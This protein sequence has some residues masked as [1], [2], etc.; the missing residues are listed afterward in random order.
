MGTLGAGPSRSKTPILA[1]HHQVVLEVFFVHSGMLVQVME[2][3]S[4]V[5]FFFFFFFAWCRPVYTASYPD[6]E[7]MEVSTSIASGRKENHSG[8]PT[9]ARSLIK[10]KHRQLPD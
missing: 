9:I 4:P 5:V 10:A 3:G 7:L 6:T 2:R 8:F 1:W